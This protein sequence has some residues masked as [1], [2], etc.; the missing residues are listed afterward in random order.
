M[1][2]VRTL[3][4][5][6]TDAVAELAR[7]ELGELADRSVATACRNATAGNPFYLH[8]LLI[9]LREEPTRSSGAL[10]QRA[11]ELAP[12][13]VIR[14]L[15]VRVGRLGAE[16][17][18]LA[19]AVAILGDDVPLRQ[20]AALAGLSVAS[21]SIAADGLAAVEIL[22]AREPLRFVHPLVRQAIADDIPVSERSS[23]HLDAARLLYADGTPSERVA[24][25]LLLGRAEGD[26]WVVEQLRN[27]AHEAR[28]RGAAQSAVTY[29]VRALEEP[30][31]G[32]QQT[33]LLAELGEVGARL[34][35]LSAPDYLAQAAQRTQDPVR[36]AQLALQRGQ[37][38][39]AQGLHQ[40]AATAYDSGVAVLDDARSGAG[41]LELR[42]ALAT[43]FVV[44]ALLIPA[45]HDAAA[46]RSA[47]LLAR[48]E[49]GR[50]A[51]DRD[52]GSRPGSAGCSPRPRCAA[53]GRA[54]RLTPS[55]SL[56][57]GPGATVS[58]SRRRT[59]T[60]S[61]GASST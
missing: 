9:A 36:R 30:A 31:D 1:C 22:L 21:A 52:C 7:L 42:D 58:C 40:A 4:P 43:G 61:A 10:A 55:S 25:H 59:L 48:T 29:L 14:T 2:R 24:A 51:E 20:A 13:A 57:T 33:E 16:A 41:A 15:R 23:R 19:R 8:E 45:L 11:L 32:E 39:E 53:P 44:S 49:G 6:G 12:D 18:A 28:A 5:L 17:A 35:L 56:P 26:A 50:E 34:G 60:A 37:A 3:D 38:L 54:S 46:E 47:E 27:A